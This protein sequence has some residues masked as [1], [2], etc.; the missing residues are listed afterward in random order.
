MTGTQDCYKN[1]YRFN[2]SR[3]LIDNMQFLT[4][5]IY[6]NL[7]TGFVLHMHARLSATTP[8]IVVMIKRCPGKAPMMS[9][10]IHFP[11]PEQGKA[12]LLQAL[13]IILE[14]N[15]EGNQTLIGDLLRLLTK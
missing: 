2:F 6:K 15:V 10:M 9:K 4:C 5:I 14:K 11:Q 3:Q 13:F 1:F 8:Q 7:I 12:T